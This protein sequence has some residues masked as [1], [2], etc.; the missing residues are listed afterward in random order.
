VDGDKVDSVELEGGQWKVSVVAKSVC[1]GRKEERGVPD[2]QKAMVIVL[3][4]GNNG[5]SA[6]KML[7]M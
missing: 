1:N 6:G 4:T 2:S 5:R 3:A 7:F